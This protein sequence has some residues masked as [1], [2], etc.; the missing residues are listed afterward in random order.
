MLNV[1]NWIQSIKN[2]YVEYTE[3]IMYIVR[4]MCTLNL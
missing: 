2:V 4:K 3:L 1:Q